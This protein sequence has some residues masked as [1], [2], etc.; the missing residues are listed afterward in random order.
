MSENPY[1]R[2]IRIFDPRVDL[3]EDKR[4]KPSRPVVEAGGD[5]FEELQTSGAQ[6]AGPGKENASGA[7]NRQ[8]SS[9]S[10]ELDV[11]EDES[12]EIIDL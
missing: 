7:E 11:V 9:G 4:N 12:M 1:L 2:P 3:A 8:K 10:G 5:L 6:A